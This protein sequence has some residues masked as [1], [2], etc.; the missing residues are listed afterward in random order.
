MTRRSR[1]HRKNDT[2]SRFFLNFSP[3]QKSKAQT[4]ALDVPTFHP[5]TMATP[6][7]KTPP[8]EEFIS[9]EEETEEDKAK[10]LEEEANPMYTPEE[11]GEEE[12][13]EEDE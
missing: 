11:S 8:P 6:G 3:L 5:R 10:R 7:S 12:E 13:E 4:A 1:L 9:S 2:F